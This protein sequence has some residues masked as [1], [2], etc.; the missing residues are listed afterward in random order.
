MKRLASPERR[1]E[2]GQTILLVAVSMV[3]MLGLAAL[4]IDVVTL[5]VARAET[6]RAA[7][8]GALAGA[9]MLVTAGVVADPCNGAL[10]TTA[11]ALAT[12]QA[13]T[14][15]AQNSISGGAGTAVVTYPN[16]VGSTNCPNAFGVNPQIQVV[17]TRSNLPTFFARI[18]GAA[19]GTVSATAVAE[20]YNPS[21]SA[22]LNATS[23]VIPISPRCAKPM[24]LP[25][26]DPTSGN[27]TCNGL[28]NTLVDPVT[29]A[30][31]VSAINKT[32]TLS[33][34]CR[35]GNPASCTPNPPATSTY[36]PLG[37]SATALHL[38]PGC[39]SSAGGFQQDLECC[40]A[41]ALTCGQQ[42]SVDYSINP[43][44][45]GL[46]AATG[47]QCMIHQSPGNGQDAL[48][49]D[50]PAV[51][52]AGPNNPFVGSSVQAN[53][54]ILTSDSVISLP[55]YDGLTTPQVGTP[56]TIIGY[57]QVFVN[58]IDNAGNFNVTVLNISGCGNAPGPATTAIQGAATSVPVRLIQSP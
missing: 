32:F 29:G 14:V 31:P 13:Q 48:V 35:P 11:Q 45:T 55:L 12:T 6:Q 41:S 36:Y 7:D 53:D 44:G 26:C 9:Q 3:A 42:A 2:R 5:Y 30:F 22:S 24:L 40:N 49:Q 25:N 21:N 18:W 4:A 58:S 15:V 43:N 56:V 46:A 34:N 50:F 54:L 10:A 27:P 8:A 39:S 47:G 52:M 37:L 17:V 23:A 16:F 20:A 1:R 51:F 38:C 57:V 33:P 19:L 28:G